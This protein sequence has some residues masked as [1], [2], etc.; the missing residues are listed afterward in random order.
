M[1]TIHQVAERAGVA[2]GTVSRYLNGENLRDSNVR[3]IEQAIKELKYV[4]KPYAR[5]LKSNKSYVVGLLVTDIES[6]LGAAIAKRLEIRFE[7]IGYTLLILDYDSDVSRLKQKIRFLESRLVD[8]I[9]LFTPEIDSSELSFIGKIKTPLVAVDSPLPFEGV[10]SIVVDNFD[11]SRSM[12]WTMAERGHRR[13]GIIA[14]PDTTYV[15]N[16]RLKGC[17]DAFGEWGIDYQEALVRFGDFTAK[18]G[19]D[20]MRTFLKDANVT[21]VFASNYN[22]AMGALRYIYEAQMTIG[23]DIAFA[24]FDDF[25]FSD[26]AYPKISVIRQP[27]DKMSDTVF[28]CLMKI[29]KGGLEAGLGAQSPIHKLTCE[30]SITDSISIV[31]PAS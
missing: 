24:S 27:L 26:I 13:I 1:T 16:E 8:G 25:G 18:S 5:S 14:A 21:A 23:E 15:G 11:A 12:I 10:E 17:L 19:Y 20:V 6:V 28:K 4:P 30:L 31:T 3:R 7:E 9:I 22:M 2:V 29:I